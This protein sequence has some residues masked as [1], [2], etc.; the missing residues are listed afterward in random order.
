M[1]KLSSLVLASTVALAGCAADDA[2]EPTRQAIVGG[3][4]DVAFPAVGA[5][6][7]TPPVSDDNPT[8]E[9]IVC[10][11]TLVGDAIALTS[12]RCLIDADTDEPFALDTIEMKFG[13][14]SF[15]AATRY[16]LSHIET[17]R[18]YGEGVGTQHEI[19][20]VQLETSPGITPVTVNT[21]AVP[22]DLA[23]VTIVGFGADEAGTE[24]DK[25]RR[26]VDVDVTN[27][28]SRTI[29][30]GTAAAT[31]CKGDSGAPVFADL[32]AGLVMVAMTEAHGDCNAS[33]PRLRTDVYADTFINAFVD[34]EEGACKADG[35][36]TTVGCRTADPDCDATGCSWDGAE[37]ATD[38][39]TRDW[40]CDLGTFVG[41]A[42]EADGE[43]ENGGGCVA[44][45]DDASFT[46]C[47]QTCAEDADCPTERGMSCADGACV[48]GT[49]SEG[50]Q[51][52]ACVSGSECRSGI[53]EDEIC[54]VECDPDGDDCAAPY[55]CGPSDEAPG[56]NVCLG[57]DL[58]GGGG[59]CAVSGGV[60]ERRRSPGWLLLLLAGLGAVGVLG[61][62]G[63]RAARPL[64]G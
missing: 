21:D 55:T 31:T 18:Y 1:L 13:N 23:A 28:T 15:G 58:D 14:A 39:P 25:Q 22:D 64:V 12:A 48:H 63:R 47:T 53:C 10:A 32:G 51:G 59:F 16:D 41:D 62:R 40:D 45:E 11:A 17:Y 19:A 54:V 27:V 43:C 29:L 26:K 38:C 34:R 4:A 2:L 52:Y 9:E 35:T 37:C 61:I 60:T 8:P 57:E 46:Y 7:V 5:M 3:S 56:T 24:P 20:L 33:V 49:P 36:C 30:A 50:S 44:A 42:C 6:A